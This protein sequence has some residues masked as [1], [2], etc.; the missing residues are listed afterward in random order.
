M[1]E[2]LA[3][4]AWTRPDPPVHVARPMLLQAWRDCA[5]LHWSVDPDALRPLVPAPFEIETFEDRAWISI[6]TFRIER[7]RPGMLPAVPG[8]RSAAETHIRTYVAGPDG[9]RG[10]W[11]TSLDI[12]P[13]QAAFLGRFAFA[14]PYWWGSMHIERDGVAF[15]SRVE[16]RRPGRG[17]FELD[18][19]VGE[20][21]TD[22]ELTDRDHFLTARWLLY[23]GLGPVRG[24]LFAEH[25]RW[26][27]RHATVVSLE[28][29]LTEADGLPPLEGDPIVHFSDGVDARLSWPRPFL[30]SGR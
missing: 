30:A 1:K 2:T 29:S 16:R 9:R 19:L 15:R 3:A 12:D 4:D 23:N 8:L 26:P 28:Q 20:P 25:P 5:F 14:L 22:A 24:A 18:L 11:F 6:I 21:F 17:R 10:I 27:L 7:M 13:P